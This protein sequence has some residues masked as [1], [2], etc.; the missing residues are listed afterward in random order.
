MEYNILHIEDSKTDADLVKRSLQKSGMNFT[1]KLASDKN[2]VIESLLTFE[3]NVVLCDHSLP[4][5]DSKM[6]YALC[7]EKKPGLPFILV[8]GTVSEEYAVEM[9]KSGVD[10]YL[11]KSNL[12]RLPI[13]IEHAV[14]KREAEEIVSRNEKR[15]SALIEKSVDMKTLASFDGK[16]FYASPSVSKILGYTLDEFLNTPPSE[17][18]HPDDIACV[19][20]N[21]QKIIQSEGSSFTS[22][23]RLKHKNG[24]YIWCEGTMTN[25]LHEPY[26]NA[27]VSNFRDISE[28]KLAEEKLIKSNRL[29]AFISAINQ[30][31]VYTKDERTLFS[32]SCL[33]AHIIGKF[34]MAWIGKFDHDNKKILLVD[35]NG[36][37]ENSIHLFSALCENNGPQDHILRSGSYYVCNDI[38]NDLYLENWKPFVAHNGIKSCIILP[39]KKEGSIVGSFNLYSTE[40]NFFDEAEIALLEEATDDIS[41]AIDVFDKEKARKEA[42][43]VIAQNRIEREFD[44]NNLNALIN[45]TNDLLWSVDRDFRL[46]TSNKPFEEM[47]K[48]N[49][50][51]A[52]QKGENILSVS[53][54]PEMLKHFKEQYE[55]AFNGESFT[56]IEH[57]EIPFEF[58]TEISYY[59]IRKGDQVIGTACHSRN[60][61]DI[62]RTEKHLQ[63]SEFFIKGILNSLDSHIAVIDESGS[64]IAVNDNWKFFAMQNGEVTLDR[65][66]VGSNYFNVCLNSSN[67]G[68]KFADE[69]LQG[70]KNVMDEKLKYF[71]MEYPCHSP[72][73]QRWFEMR[74]MKFDSDE[75]RIVVAHTDISALK[76]KEK[77]VSKKNEELKKLTAYLQKV[78]EQERTII[79]REIHDELGQQV[80]ALKMDI[81]W[82]RHKQENPEEAIVSKLDQ[83]TYMSNELITTIRRISSDLRPAIIDDFGLIA[84]LEWKCKDFEEKTGI[85]CSF[86]S[87]VKERKFANEFSINVY[88]IL[89]E[90]LT[91]VS[92][93]AAAKSVSVSVSEG[94]T[95]FV[96]EIIDDG[97]G[98]SNTDIANGKTL[99]ILGMKE[100]AIVLGGKLILNGEKGKGT[101]TTLILPL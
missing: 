84:A 35:Q 73:K 89:Q 30:I 8:T 67:N 18:I 9:L 92:R 33:I 79:A 31:I 100:R 56:E 69:A 63:E 37:P 98:I 28:R 26:L 49:F 59:P 21:V 43:T 52:I 61:T 83:M 60:I 94:K 47:G 3:P 42:E 44:R 51:K 97:K 4:S 17:M 74:V 27:I 36:I 15:F 75:P 39:I 72:T 77:E 11:L 34:E 5:F 62:K 23:H 25:L 54:T 2:E 64:I 50:G 76:K 19:F 87:T 68:E 99:G 93:H 14:L 53:Y 12:Q 22:Q 90:T 80:T 71:Y 24:N 13:A 78:R 32:K 29:Y 82:V 58:W 86:E 96:L 1:Y 6:A 7:K 91:N 45:N 41:F 95:K 101:L 57:F 65:T 38:Q 16:L 70:M 20:E 46:I 48:I 66:G 88:R 85:T 81:D 40:I 10:D 55:R